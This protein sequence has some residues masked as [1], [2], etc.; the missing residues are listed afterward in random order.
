MREKL[1]TTTNKVI[2]EALIT[3]LAFWMAYQIRFE[4]SVPSSIG[5]QFQ[6]FV[7]P[8][9]A[10]RLAVNAAWGISNQR[11]RYAGLNDALQLAGAYACFT[12]LFL[13]FRLAAPV[14]ELLRVP[15]GVILIEFLLSMFGA[16]AARLLRRLLHERESGGLGDVS[17][18]RLLLVGAG[19][20]GATVAR[21]MVH[22]R[23]LKLVGFVDDDPNKHGK[24]I[25]GVK[26]LGP[27]RDLPEIVK[28]ERVSDVLVCVPPPARSGL[29]MSVLQRHTV[30]MRVIP[31][32]AELLKAE[33]EPGDSVAVAAQERTAN[34]KPLVL[35]SS[36]AR[37][38]VRT[39]TPLALRNKTI[40]IT[41]GAGFIGSNLAERLAAQNEVIL[42]DTTFRQKPV[43]FTT[44]PSNPNVRLVE[45]NLLDDP[46][47]PGLCRSADIVVHAAAVVGV[48]RVCNAARET[49]ETNYVGTSRLLKM[50][51]ANPSLQRFLYFSTSEVFGVN[52]YRVDESSVTNVGSISESRWSYAIAKLAG[53]HLVESYFRETRMPIV[54]VRPFNVF[55][56]RRT[57]DHALLQF[58]LNA[59]AGVPLNV[60]GDGSQ[61]RSWCFIEDFCSALVAMLE[62]DEAVGQ[63]FNIGHPGNTVTILDLARKVV[64]IAGSKSPVVCVD[65]P[66][67]DISIRVPCTS[68]AQKLLGYEPRF[69]LDE[70]LELTIEWYA[71][72]L[73]RFPDPLA[74]MQTAGSARSVAAAG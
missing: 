40:L 20:Q 71:R 30:R 63:D 59:L 11:W 49:L 18:R 1:F 17:P 52:S 36:A 68:K 37:E 69:R 2:I 48:S 32:L 56:P 51:E 45:G 58:I 35:P 13:L 43:E 16:L 60:H 8:V 70:A 54:I 23:G 22:R 38:R 67:P 3:G 73:D 12:G 9:V 64:E 62:R 6:I 21:E 27:T 7:L 47:L 25:A 33:S 74:T 24:T 19:S 61:I 14:S 39:V 34:R 41:G 28:A 46:E 15:I 72:N 42:Y 50:V 4:G 5:S 10:G 65:H 55:G 66:F 31:S 44:L 26:V 53:E 29:D 57:G